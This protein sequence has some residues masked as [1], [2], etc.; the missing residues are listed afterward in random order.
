[1]VTILPNDPARVE[2]LQALSRFRTGVRSC[3]TRRG[4]ALFELADAMLCTQG[5][6]RSAVELSME[7]EFRRGHGA[8]F[9]ALASGRVSSDRL[10]RL[11]TSVATGPRAGQPWM[12]AIDTTPHARPDAEYAN[13]RLMIGV[14]GKGGDRYLPGWPYSIL[15]GLG[16]GSSSWVD[17]IEARRIRPHEDH[18][19]VTIDQITRLLSDLE[20]T[21]RLA[22]HQPPPLVILDAGNPATDISFALAGMP[23]Q[24]LVRLRSTRVFHTESEP[25]A[26]GQ[27]GAPRRHGQRF[28]CRDP[29]QRHAPDYEN[30]E[31][32]DRYGTVVVRAWGGLHQRLTRTGR[33]ADHPVD[34][35]LPIVSGT[36][37]QVV[38]E[39]LPDGREPLKDLWL[40]HAGP[41]VAHVDLLWKAYLRRF[42]QEHF[43]RFTK[44]HL[45]LVRAHLQSA[46]ATDRWVN[47]VMLA[48]AQLRLAS[49]L[50]DDLRRPWHSKPQPGAVLSPYR[51]RLGFRRLRASLGTPADSPKFTRP[52]PGRPKGSRN[53][54]KPKHPV[55]RKTDSKI[56]T[57]K[58]D[59]KA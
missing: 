36:V 6:V 51:V 37:I 23:V 5:P 27:R 4:D 39:H 26:P 12:F 48:Y 47:L 32:S 17:P 2:S 3:L 38:V 54:P 31:Q 15:V 45:G 50:V 34:Q 30:T 25:R 22:P 1:V 57:A 28:S 33:W 55:H 11:L 20:A 14:R 29:R 40:W 41:V 8:L 10:R 53:Q 59:T 13:E 35:Q 42:D 44:V 58:R 9:D 21:G 16:W 52:G 24:V 56:S 46:A 18:T 7:P 43:H 19:D 49:P